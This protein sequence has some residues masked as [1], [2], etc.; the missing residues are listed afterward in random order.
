MNRILDI[1]AKDLLQILRDRKVFMFLLIM[2]IAFT[3]LFGLAFSGGGDENNDPRLPVGFIDQDNSPLSAELKGLLASS[4]VIKLVE[5]P[6]WTAAGL[7]K[8]VADNNL[9]AA[10]II[11]P[12]YGKALRE[13]PIRLVV[14]AKPSN[15]ASSTVQS[16]I[17]ALASRLASAVRAAQAVRQVTGGQVAGGQSFDA[18]LQQALA[19][20]QQPPIRIDS[21]S[22]KAVEEKSA[23]GMSAAHSSPGMMLQFAIASL[24][25]SAQVI[26]NERKSRSLQRLLTTATARVHILLGHYLAILAMIALQFTL[27]IA[28]GQFFMGVDYLRVPLGSLLVA[29]TAALCIAAMGLL[30]G[31]LAKSDEQAV[32]F[33]LLP[34]FIFAGLGGAWTPLEYTSPAFQTIGHL[35]PVAWAMDGFKNIVARGLDFQSILL[36]SAALAGYAVLFFAVAAWWLQ[37]SEMQ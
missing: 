24:L 18:L 16:E 15:T 7:E 30:I 13:V 5:D 37:R 3:V 32:I 27:L 36:P 6:A 21:R 1:T 35:T 26:V 34:M 4:T 2:P 11:P 14:I 17:S 23:G 22:G 8:E 12:G 20:W 31:V 9:S 25:T 19:S 29:F 33:S 28:F 10:L